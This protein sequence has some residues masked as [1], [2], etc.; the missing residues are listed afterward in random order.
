MSNGGK[1]KLDFRQPTIQL[2]AFSKKTRTGHR[3]VHVSL[4]QLMR[5]MSLLDKIFETRQQ[6]FKTFKLLFQT[7]HKPQTFPFI[8]FLYIKPKPFFNH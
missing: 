1:S 3:N 7:F 2:L 5:R 6:N 8:N 4:G